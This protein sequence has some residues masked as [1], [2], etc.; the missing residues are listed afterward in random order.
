MGGKPITSKEM[1]NHLVAKHYEGALQAKKEGRPVVWATSICPQELLETMD[2]TT[3]YPE[4]HA[5]AI[6][7]RK[8]ALTFN[9]TFRS[10]RLFGGYLFLCE[11]K[12][13]ICGYSACR[14]TG[15][16]ASGF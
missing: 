3:V 8:E 4:N 2:L 1:L 15:Y 13:G 7:A 6:G 12:Y 5:A 16:T 10:G 14:G 11:G 9:R